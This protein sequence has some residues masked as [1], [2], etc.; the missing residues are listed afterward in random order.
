MSKNVFITGLTGFLGRFLARELLDKGCHVYGLARGNKNGTAAQRVEAALKFAYDQ[1]WRD[2]LMQSVTVIEGDITR[3]DLGMSDRAVQ[4]EV[5]RSMD[6]IVHSA[7]LAELNWDYDYISPINVDGTRCVC[8]FAR[9]CFENGRLR[10]LHH[11]STMY[12]AGDKPC[13]FDEACFDEGQG[14]HNTYEQTK[15]EAERIVRGYQKKYGLPVSIHRPSMIMGE[16]LHGRTPN[17]NLIYQPLHFFSKEIYSVFPANLESGQNLI[18][19]DRVAKAMSVLLNQEEERVYHLISPN[20]VSIKLFVDSAATFFDF[21]QPRC[22]PSE[23]FDFSQLTA[24]QRSLCE[25]YVSYFN[26]KIKFDASKTFETLKGLS[27]QMLEVTRENLNKVYQYC[28]QS[29]FIK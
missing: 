10:H 14:F 6:L 23:Y 11:V 26:Y 25:P 13:I 8:D 9:A 4:K 18:H 22:I 7:A 17:F 1:D 5:V 28:R 3:T 15:F 21:H 29:G 24:V 20:D 19:M 2:G 16:S 12:I 27:C